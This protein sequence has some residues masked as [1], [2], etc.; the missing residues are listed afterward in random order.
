MSERD[1]LSTPALALM[2]ALA[3]TVLIIVAM[4]VTD[5]AQVVIALGIA[6]TLA[7]FLMLRWRLRR[8]LARRD[9]PAAVRRTGSGKLLSAGDRS[10]PVNGSRSTAVDDVR[11][12][13][14]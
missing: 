7:V 10:W 9:P 1:R 3:P 5:G 11:E 8:R 6:A 14:S 4:V 12:R 2:T 13:V